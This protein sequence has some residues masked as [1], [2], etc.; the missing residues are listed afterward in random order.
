MRPHLVG[1]KTRV[2]LLSH[3]HKQHK[4]HIHL[5]LFYV[6]MSTNSKT[7]MRPI[8]ASARVAAA[9]TAASTSA[10]TPPKKKQ[11]AVPVPM[12]RSELKRDAKPTVILDLPSDSE[13]EQQSDDEQQPLKKKSKQSKQ[14]MQDGELELRSYMHLAVGGF[15]DGNLNRYLVPSKP[16]LS[17]TYNATT[18]KR[19]FGKDLSPLLTSFALD[20]R[21]DKGFIF[22][23]SLLRAD[24]QKL[25]IS[26]DYDNTED[27]KDWKQVPSSL[28]LGL[29]GAQ[30][31]KF[32]PVKIA[33]LKEDVVFVSSE[34][35][36]PDGCFAA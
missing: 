15:S 32:R 10:A 31:L 3:A 24:P 19:K 33:A 5:S 14:S 26:L 1:D 23:S 22:Y 34:P 12:D 4:Q 27:S 8:R 30:P 20:P 21:P 25:Y 2:P 35:S 11:A 9:A 16:T 36:H 18:E 28:G 17:V 7:P 29:A 13:G 6:K